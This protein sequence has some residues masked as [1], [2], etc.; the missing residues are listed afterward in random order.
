MKINLA[1]T[2]IQNI[3]DLVKDANPLLS[4]TETQFTLSAPVIAAGANGRNTEITLSAV[5]GQG[6]TGTKTVSYTRLDPV[7]GPNEGAATTGVEVAADAT[8]EAIKTQLVALFG[9][10]PAEVDVS[11]L[12]LPTE[13]VDGSIE[14]VAD[15]DSVFYVG[16]TTVKLKLQAE[17][18][19][20]GTEIGQANL[21]GFEPATA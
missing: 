7:T 21:N 3:L 18:Q 2:G 17:E 16:S 8:A 15:A 5:A 10:L 14:I 19:D 13:G 9:I 20:L 4:L 6:K 11:G 1:R 12:V